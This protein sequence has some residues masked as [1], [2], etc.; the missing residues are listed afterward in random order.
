MSACLQK[1][2]FRELQVFTK[3]QAGKKVAAGHP[4][5]V[6]QKLGLPGFSNWHYAVVIGYDLEA[7]HMI[8]RSGDAPRVEMNFG[9]FQQVWKPWDKWAIITLL[10]DELPVTYEK[11]KYL[12]ATQGLKKVNP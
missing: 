9:K 12:K 2:A 10:P 8:L 11:E 7:G 5:I 4:V 3:R 1:E 6:L